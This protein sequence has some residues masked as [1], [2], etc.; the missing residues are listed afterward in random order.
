MP[1][2]DLR[3]ILAWDA[4]ETDVDL[5]VTEPSGE[6]AF[7]GHRRT[8][9]GGDVSR[10]ITDGYGPEEYLIRKAP[11]GGYRIRAHY[12]ASHQQEVF[13]PATATATIFTDWGRPNQAFQTLS[14]RL[15]KARQMIDLGE[16]AIGGDGKAAASPAASPSLRKGMTVEE[17]KAILG[18][19][20]QVR[21]NDAKGLENWEFPRPG[22]RTCRISFKN[23]ALYSAVEILPGGAETILVQ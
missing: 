20:S 9:V 23:G 8:R 5:H 17:V 2:C 13:G 16:V 15:D 18:E 22:G 10:D 7:Y 6:E 14:I 11:A 1:A 4:D 12:Y 19:G 21:G 3:I